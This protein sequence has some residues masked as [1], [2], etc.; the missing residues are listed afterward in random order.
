M[1]RLAERTAKYRVNYDE[2]LTGKRDA[3]N[4]GVSL[5][6]SLGEFVTGKRVLLIGD[7]FSKMTMAA[8]IIDAKS[9]SAID[10]GP[11]DAHPVHLVP[12]LALRALRDS[13]NTAHDVKWA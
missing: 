13:V 10:L 4:V 2:F 12:V 8:A 6:V 5:G 1:E 7:F 3:F 11:F 9:A